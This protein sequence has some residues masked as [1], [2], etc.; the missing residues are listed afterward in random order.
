[1]IIFKGNSPG[2]PSW[3]ERFSGEESA[4]DPAHHPAPILLT[5]RPRSV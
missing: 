5:T 1:M 4:P 3:E 2:F